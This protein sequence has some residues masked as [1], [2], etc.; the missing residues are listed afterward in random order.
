MGVQMR[1]LSI[2]VLLL[3]ISGPAAADERV[4]SRD[5]IL[6][7]CTVPDTEPQSFDLIDF[8][9]DEREASKKIPDTEVHSIFDV[10]RHIGVAAGYDN[11]AAHGSIGFYLTIA[12][13]G[14]WNFGIPAVEFGFVHHP[15]YNP[16]SQQTIV[17]SE[18]TLFV[19]L[20]SVHYRVG[21]LRSFGLNWYINLEQIYDLRDNVPGSQFGFSFSRK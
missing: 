18:P 9:Q 20:A 15:V 11:R 7:A 10:K 14:R 17:R 5:L 16:R 3:A 8:R 19:S 4:P 13:W 6:P 2:L 21:Y 1:S 12:E